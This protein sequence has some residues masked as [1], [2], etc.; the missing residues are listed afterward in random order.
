[1]NKEKIRNYNYIKLVNNRIKESNPKKQVQLDKRIN[2]ES[3]THSTNLTLKQGLTILNAI[4]KFSINSF[5]KK[6]YSS[7]DL[8]A[9]QKL[10]F[11]DF[12][13]KNISDYLDCKKNYK[14]STKIA[15][16]S[17][18]ANA[19][20]GCYIHLR[21]KNLHPN[22]LYI[23]STT[24]RLATILDIKNELDKVIKCIQKVV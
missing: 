5:V 1:M 9:N 3:S 19:S 17:H 16:A 4:K 14:L 8:K 20:L 7:N 12:K 2:I 18:S 13:I 21:H 10:Y 6:H 22:N 15:M 24:P 23:L 11:L